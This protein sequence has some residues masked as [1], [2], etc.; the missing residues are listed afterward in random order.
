MKTNDVEG[1]RRGTTSR[2]GVALEALA[3]LACAGVLPGQQAAPATSPPA[4]VIRA[5]TLIDGTGAAP[6]KN[7]VIVVQ[8]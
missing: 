2:R 5:G 8:G 3:V 4:I 6:V 7:A 1:G